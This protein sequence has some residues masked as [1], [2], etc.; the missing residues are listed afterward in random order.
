[1]CRLIF[2]LPEW[3]I[4]I[5]N[6]LASYV[7]VTKAKILRLHYRN[8]IEK[9]GVERNEKLKNKSEKSKC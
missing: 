7:P 9:T 5:F 1:M 8:L 3:R 6:P 4:R 2:N